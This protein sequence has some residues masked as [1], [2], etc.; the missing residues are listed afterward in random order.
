MN[1]VRAV[2]DGDDFGTIGQA[3]LDFSKPGFDVIDDG[4][5]VL[6]IALNG[7]AG[8]HFT[9]AIQFRDA[10]PLIWRQLNARNVAQQNGRAALGF[11]DDLFQVV[12]TPNITTA[13]HHVFPL[14]EFNDPPAGVHVGRADR[15]ADFHQGN[16]ERFEAAW[17]DDNRVLAHETTGACNFG[18]AF[19]FGE[20]EADLPVLS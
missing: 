17:I 3:A 1:E 9:F 2:I 10:A 20:S 11:D 14:G 15:I 5:S 12:Q 18:D 8:R 16:V 4:Q 19:G 13:A 7:D 6:A